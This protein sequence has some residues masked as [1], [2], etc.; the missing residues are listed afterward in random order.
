M[1]TMRDFG[2]GL[3]YLKNMNNRLRLRVKDLLD[4]NH[5]I[6]IKYDYTCP[7]LPMY[8]HQWIWDSCFHS[9]VLS[10]LDSQR[11]FKEIK[12]LLSR[13][14]D[15]GFI[16]C[17][18]IWK[19]NIP[20][21][22]AFYINKITQP[23]VIPYATELIYLNTNN[24]DFVKEIYTQLKK[25]MDWFPVNRDKNGNGLIE[26]IHPW[27][28]GD[29][30]N[31]SFDKQMGYGSKPS[32]TK[33]FYSLFRIL[34]GY[35]MMQWNEEKIYKSNIFR[36]ETVLF[37]SIYARS[38]LS[39]SRLARVID[40]YGDILI[41]KKRYEDLKKSLINNCWNKEDEIFYDLD[42]EGKQVKTKVISSLMALILPDLPKNIIK[43]LIEKHLLNEKEF[44][45]PIPIASVSQDE[46]SFNPGKTFQLWRGPMW[47][48]T[49]WFLVRALNNYGYTKDAKEIIEKTKKTI[50][51]YGFWEFYNPLSGEGYGQP[52][53][54]WSTLILDMLPQ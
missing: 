40:N 4:K 24:K 25:F 26:I 34:T 39:M 15:D 36:A 44:W 16:S 46:K 42:K 43:P 41:Y 13:Q 28:D 50:E 49:N 20:F 9:I 22:E 48:N 37:N 53:F 32:T 35:S 52:N 3:L 27:E 29:D 2:V 10:R 31:P 6:G 23:P 30:G 19:R 21:E 5:K 51:K 38:L 8:P 33:Y 7:S 18:S 12:T 47:V 45:T 1:G 14:K 54:G 11:S 17:V